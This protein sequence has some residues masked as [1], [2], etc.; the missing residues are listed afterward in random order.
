[1]ST[2]TEIYFCTEGNKARL[3]QRSDFSKEKKERIRSLHVLNKRW[4]WIILFHF[5]LWLTSAWVAVQTDIVVINLVCYLIGGLALSTLPVLTHE[6]THNLFTHRP[7]IDRWIGF[8]C[9][10]PLLL[11]PTGYRERH[12][13]HH[14]RVRTKDDPDDIERVTSKSRILSTLYM[15]MLVLG[16]YIFL[17]DVPVQAY[18]YGSRKTRRTVASEYGAI[19]ALHVAAW[20]LLPSSVMIEGWLVP[21][22]ITIQIANIRGLAEHGLTSTGNELIDTR[23]VITHPIVAFLICNINYHLEH[24]LYPG[25]PWYNLP[26]LHRILADEFRQAGSSVYTSYWSFIGDVFRAL[27]TGVIPGWRLIPAHLRKEICL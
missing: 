18:R 22:L 19:L 17:F 14:K 11:S 9:S 23:T 26:K 5:A 6:S 21:M 2:H 13:L 16:A 3:I 24:H 27:K 7:K 4:N 1:M 10:V 8:L 25:V 15:L 12:P 20:T